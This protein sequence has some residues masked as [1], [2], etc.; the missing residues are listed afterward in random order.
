MGPHNMG[1]CEGLP[2]EARIE[3]AK[4]RSLKYEMSFKQYQAAPA[5]LDMLWWLSMR[6]LALDGGD[7]DIEMVSP[8]VD[9]KRK[10]WLP[11]R[12]YYC[13][14]LPTGSL[15]SSGI[16]YYRRFSGCG[17]TRES[18][19]YRIKS[20][21]LV[22]F[23]IQPH[24]EPAAVAEQGIAAGDVNISTAVQEVLK[25]AFIHKG[26][27][28]AQYFSEEELEK[29]AKETQTN[30]AV[31]QLSGTE[32]EVTFEG[33]LGCF[34]VLAIMNNAAMNIAE[35]VS[36]LYDLASFGYLAQER[37]H[38]VLRYG[39]SGQ[40]CL[41][42]DFS[43]IALSFSPFTLMLDVC[44][45]YIAFIMFRAASAQS[46]AKVINTSPRFRSRCEPWVPDPT[47][48]PDRS[49]GHRCK[50]GSGSHRAGDIPTAIRK[51]SS[52]V[53]PSSLHS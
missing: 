15:R 6:D 42:P 43:G 37:Y 10:R 13:F 49:C 12:Q 46:K 39:E 16:L 23:K 22:Q 18:S 48:A 1:G 7:T 11:P 4:F 41:V 44:L 51:Q 2:S 3:L 9:P 38:W 20:E 21:S 19:P 35:Q 40:P 24:P 26:F 52:I 17:T 34:Q 50:P 25:T 32:L 5:E 53:V 33:Y 27:H 47:W 8:L 28:L 36:L 29:K 45:L 31:V 30:P 14:L